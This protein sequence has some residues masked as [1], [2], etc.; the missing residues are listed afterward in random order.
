MVEG[1]IKQ[2]PNSITKIIA[3][4]GSF[5]IELMNYVGTNDYASLIKISESLVEKYGENAKLT[6]N[7]IQTYF[8]REDSIP[9]VARFQNEIIGYIIGIPLE[10]LDRE[11]WARLDINFGEK[12][13]IYTYAFVIQ[14]P[15]KG[16]G[17]AKMLKKV[18][19]NWVKKQENI[20]YMTGHVMQ[21]ISSKFKG[22][23]K[24]IDLINNWQGTGKIFEYYRREID[25]D[26]LYKK[27][28][29]TKI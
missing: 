27:N 24:I 5:Q 9:F 16:N 8:N 10:L 7:T 15:F 25:P 2:E 21:G 18:Y 17:Y 12:N 28:L 6:P 29:T 1:Y 26:N 13:T 23:I 11:P 3:R 19:L 22:E 4:S 14:I 20:A